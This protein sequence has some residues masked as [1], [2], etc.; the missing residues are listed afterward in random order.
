MKNE[1]IKEE[2]KN[3]LKLSDIISKKINLKKKN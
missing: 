2:I 3:R 1:E